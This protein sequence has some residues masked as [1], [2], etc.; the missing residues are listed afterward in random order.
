MG[1]R[2]CKVKCGVRSVT[3]RVWSVGAECAMWSVE[4]EV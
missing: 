1:I 3:C 2:K 4:A